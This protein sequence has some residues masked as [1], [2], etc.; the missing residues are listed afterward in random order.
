MVSVILA[1]H[2]ISCALGIISSVQG[3]VCIRPNVPSDCVETWLSS[4]AQQMDAQDKELTPFRAYT[5]ALHAAASVIVHPYFEK[6]ANETER[7]LLVVIVFLGGFMWTRVI[8]KTTAIATSMDHHNIAY[9]ST[10]D[11]LNIQM[12][13]LRLPTDLRKR[14][15]M[16]FMATRRQSERNVWHG[17]QTRMS[18]QLR[19]EVTYWTN[20]GWLRRVPYLANTSRYFMQEIAMKLK[21]EH[22]GLGETFGS[23]FKL[24][25]LNRGLA[26]WSKSQGK[27][28][29]LLPGT[30]WGEEHLLLTNPDIMIPN[31]SRVVTFVEV[32]NL[33]RSDFKSVCGD[34]PEFDSQMKKYYLW[35][36]MVRTLIFAANKKR[37]EQFQE[38]KLGKHSTHDDHAYDA[39]NDINH[40]LHEQEAIK[41]QRELRK[42]MRTLSKELTTTTAT[43][44]DTGTPDAQAAIFAR[45]D[46]IED[47]TSRR[48]E[49]LETCVERLPALH[50][51]AARFDLAD[52]PRHPEQ[53][54]G[55]GF[56]QERLVH[57]PGWLRQPLRNR[58]HAAAA[59][60]QR[61][62]RRCAGPVLTDGLHAS[63]AQLMSSMS[64]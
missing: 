21:Q 50:G 39:H 32:L 9:H 29:V 18:P 30:V 33:S 62:N 5:V 38:K 52:A 58:E 56:G 15:R 23:N 59:I 57:G 47:R 12:K 45:L 63:W 17:I 10:M 22:F 3:E 4:A 19:T 42:S 46:A 48:I 64:P 37:E 35:Y 31:T 6:A 49:Q 41:A 24:Y 54:A 34:H 2:F 28:N 26:S 1:S 14:L 44:A 36:T 51:G 8:S 7:L 55:A 27:S 25:I 13:E 16:Y 53:A 61:D 43:T 40:M 20:K 60:Q 11:D